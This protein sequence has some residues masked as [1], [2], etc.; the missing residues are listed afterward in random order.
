MISVKPKRAVK[1]LNLISETARG[2]GIRLYAVGGCVRD[3]A[4]GLESQ[5]ADFLTVDEAAPLAEALK[6]KLGGGFTVFREFRT[7]R[8]F[9]SDGTRIDIAG[10]RKENY[11][12]AAALPVVAPAYSVEEDLGRRD[13]SCNS[14][15]VRLD[16]G[17]FALTDPYG[18]LED[19]KAGIISVLHENSFKDDPTR[20]YRGARFAGRFGW[21]FGASTKILAEK[22]VGE[23][24]PALLSRQR[25]RN[26]LIK[27]LKEKKPYGSFRLLKELGALDFIYPGTVFSESTFENGDYLARLG[28]LAAACGDSE[29]FVKSL[30]LSRKDSRLVL[31][32]AGIKDKI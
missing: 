22:A 2:L 5:D 15:A 32:A 12:K 23:R 10:S 30:F 8:Y 26:E 20:I 27:L 13:F 18:G 21:E 17:S 25:L 3:W 9:T 6:E 11:P 4:I 28:K 24:Y 29:N 14:M 16:D 1:Y 7:V 19:V 31:E